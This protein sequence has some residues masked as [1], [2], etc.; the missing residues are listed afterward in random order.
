MIQ[1]NVIVKWE[2][3]EINYFFFKLSFVFTIFIFFIC[4]K[5]QKLK[6]I[7]YLQFLHIN[8][9]SNATHI[10]SN[11]YNIQVKQLSQKLRLKN[12]RRRGILI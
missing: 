9:T 2:I 6:T 11:T 7:S 3:W 5:N 4:P 8:L 12:K 10:Q 1:N